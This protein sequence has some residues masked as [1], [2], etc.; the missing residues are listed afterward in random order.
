MWKKGAG[1]VNG[2]W[3]EAGVSLCVHALGGDFV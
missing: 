3:R 1:D 2:E